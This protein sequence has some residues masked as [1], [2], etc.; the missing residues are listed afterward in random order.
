MNA[1]WSRTV[2]REFDA[3]ARRYDALATLQQ[4]MARR[5]AEQCRRTEILSGFWVDLG[6]GTG[7]LA[8]A[9]EDLSEGL[10]VWSQPPTLLASSFVLHWLPEPAQQLKRWWDALAPG[11]VLALSVP[12]KGSFPQWHAAATAADV[13]CTALPLPDAQQLLAAIPASAIQLQRQLQ[14]TQS[15]ADPLHLLRPM[16]ELGAGTTSAPQLSAAVWRRLL[17]AWPEANGRSVSL[18]WRI[19]LVLLRR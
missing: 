1:G 10:P 2:L 15:A 6:S 9:L 19:L 5:L 17:R 12:I 18:S 3:S 14:F 11:G 4:A 13:P 7:Q 8:E 16:A